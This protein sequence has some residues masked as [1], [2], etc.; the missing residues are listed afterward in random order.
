MTT[1]FFIFH[2]QEAYR[3]TLGHLVKLWFPHLTV[4][5]VDYTK[6]LEELEDKNFPLST[7]G[8]KHFVF[9]ED[10]DDAVLY[11][12]DGDESIV[13]GKFECLREAESGFHPPNNPEPRGRLYEFIRNHIV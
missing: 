4:I 1:K 12:V 6:P 2:H 3:K 9:L 10:G 11:Y 5:P 7:E 13:K 8:E